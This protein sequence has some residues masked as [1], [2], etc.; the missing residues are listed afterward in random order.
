MLGLQPLEEMRPLALA[1]ELST[2]LFISVFEEAYFSFMNAV[3]VPSLVK[4]GHDL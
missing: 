4:V 3:K 2:V 1:V